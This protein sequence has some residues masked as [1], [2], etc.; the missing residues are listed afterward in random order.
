KAREK[1]AA[2]KQDKA[3]RAT[4]EQHFDTFLHTYVPTRGRKGDVQEDNLDCPLVELEFIIKVGDRELDRSAG[5]R[6]P[7]YAFR[8]DEKPDITQ[9]LF[10]YCLQDFWQ[11]RHGV[12]A[13]LPLREV[14]HGHGSP[15]QVFKLPED[16]VRAR[17]ADL[18]QLSDGLFAYSESASLQ[19]LRRND[20]TTGT[21]LLKGVYGTGDEHV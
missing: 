15:G 20:Q 7:I 10:R 5:R 2:A 18:A 16:D 8:R 12:E 3:S 19:Q 21:D 11:N 6:E 9:E 14:A 13:T 17:V 4:V 1:E